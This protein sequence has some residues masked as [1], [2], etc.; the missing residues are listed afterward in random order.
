MIVQFAQ[1]TRLHHSCTIHAQ[2]QTTSIKDTLD[3]STG[4]LAQFMSQKQ[5]FEQFDDIISVNYFTWSCNISI[6]NE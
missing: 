1:H 6:P 2:L 5:K 3:L 4:I